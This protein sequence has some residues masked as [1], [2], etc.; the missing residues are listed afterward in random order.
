MTATDYTAK[1]AELERIAPGSLL[2][3][4]LRTGSSTV[5]DVLLT[6]ALKKAKEQARPAP[7]SESDDPVGDE[8]LKAMRIEQRKLF[9]ER[10]ALSNRFHG[11]KTN[12]DRAAISEDIQVVQ[13]NIER[14]AGW[15]RQYK[16]H[17]TLP[18]DAERKYY[19]P[20]DGLELAK[21]RNSLRVMISRKEKLLKEL[22]TNDLSH[23]ATAR[24]VE[25]EE[26]KLTDLKAQLATIEKAIDDL[27]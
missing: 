17:G 26:N 3:N 25:V 5:N 16:V 1:L 12:P 4:K 22:R 7:D 13:R 9:S 2:L 11:C 20:K 24:K 6:N 10:A 19:V 18:D 14:L 15:I 21:K 23:P 8:R 27:Q